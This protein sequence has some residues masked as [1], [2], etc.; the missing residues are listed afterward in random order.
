[1]AVTSREQRLGCSSSPLHCRTP[2]GK[3]PTGLEGCPLLVAVLPCR[4]ETAGGLACLSFTL[5]LDKFITLKKYE[6]ASQS[7]YY[8]PNI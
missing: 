5:N 1:M 2:V 6:Y 3:P 7:S 8:K 4:T